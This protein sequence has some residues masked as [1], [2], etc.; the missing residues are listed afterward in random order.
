MS[1]CGG[2]NETL[3]DGGSSLVVVALHVTFPDLSPEHEACSFPSPALLVVKG[4]V[5]ASPI[6]RLDEGGFSSVT[7]S[8]T[9]CTTLILTGLPATG[10]PDCEISN[11][12][13]PVELGT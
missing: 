4:R 6:C 10:L 7:L 13:L 9:L 5:I 2:T 8:A 11:L 3:A 12:C 1:G